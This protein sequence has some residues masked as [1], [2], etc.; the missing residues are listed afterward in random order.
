M[1]S[2]LLLA[3][4]VEITEVVY[5]VGERKG[6]TLG[7]IGGTPRQFRELVNRACAVVG[8]YGAILNTVPFPNAPPWN[9]VP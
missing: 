9:V 5:R 2:L 7:E 1:A 6:R 3:A 8:R 4:M